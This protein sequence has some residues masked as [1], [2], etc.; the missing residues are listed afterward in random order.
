MASQFVTPGEYNGVNSNN[1]IGGL[2]CTLTVIKLLR[3]GMYVIPRAA[4]HGERERRRSSARGSRVEYMKSEAVPVPG[5]EHA[6]A[7]R[8]EVRTVEQD[9]P[10]QPESQAQYKENGR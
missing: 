6:A 1:S 8:S 3:F 10:G 2:R 7:G 4:A 9:A 5:N